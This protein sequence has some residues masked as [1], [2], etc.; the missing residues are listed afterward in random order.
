MSSAAPSEHCP[1]CG[2]STSVALVGPT[3]DAVH[4]H[5]RY[6]LLGCSHCDLRFWS[7]LVADPTIYAH[8]GYEAYTDY[9]AG[10][11]PFPRWAEPLF[12]RLPERREAA[13]DIGCGDGAVL[14][15]L[16]EANFDPHGIDLDERSVAVAASKYGLTQVQARTLGDYAAES[17]ASHRR[18]GLI[19]F[20]EVLEH[21]D[22][23]IQ[24]LAEVS[25]LCDRDALIAGSVPNRRRFLASADRHL[26]DGDLPP[27]HFLWFS[28]KS[29]RL[30]LERAG[31]TEVNVITAGHLPIREV[32]PRLDKVVR[33]RSSKWPSPL[34]ALA[35]GASKL[36]A[37]PVWAGFQMR[38]THLF[39]TCRWPSGGGSTPRGSD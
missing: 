20:F 3:H 32:I 15:R 10:Q 8:E 9:H 29:L 24:F 35:L 13:L 21:Q 11:R 12:S 6:T 16:R 36:A 5:A 38:P 23:P 33:R 1:S 14:A 37:L 17:R 25:T 34:R 18:F 7:P 27:H 26:G 30:L 4:N 22:N 31:F 28:A 19:T 39:F 2:A